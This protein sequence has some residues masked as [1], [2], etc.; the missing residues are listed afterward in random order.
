MAS[1]SVRSLLVVVVGELGDATG[2]T[3]HFRPNE[4]VRADGAPVVVNAVR[5]AASWRELSVEVRHEAD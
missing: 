5:L 3:V 4:T 2:T 1:G